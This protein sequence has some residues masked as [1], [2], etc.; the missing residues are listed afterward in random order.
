MP[1]IGSQNF[2]QNRCELYSNSLGSVMTGAR[3]EIVQPSLQEQIVQSESAF[4]E[5]SIPVGKIKGLFNEFDAVLDPNGTADYADIQ[6]ALSDGKTHLYLK[7][8]T[9][10]LTA[11]LVIS[12]NDVSIQGESRE[13]VIIQS[14]ATEGAAN[15]IIDISGDRCTIGNIYKTG[16]N[17]STPFIIAVSGDDCVIQN[18]HIKNAVSG[19]KGIY[20]DTGKGLKVINCVIET[21]LYP[22]YTTQ[23]QSQILD[24]YIDVANGNSTGFYLGGDGGMFSR[25]RYIRAGTG[26]YGVHV[27]GTNWSVTDNFMYSSSTAGG[28][29]V[30]VGGSKNKISGNRI[31]GFY[32]GIH[33]SAD[34]GVTIE[35]N[36][37]FN[38]GNNGID[39]QG[40][41][42]ASYGHHVTANNTIYTCGGNGISLRYGQGHIIT[43]NSVYDATY[44][45]FYVD[46]TVN[47]F[48]AIISHNQAFYCNNGFVGLQ[49]SSFHHRCSWIGNQAYQSV[50]KGFDINQYSSNIIGNIDYAGGAASSFVSM[51]G[52]VQY[53]I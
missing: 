7:N 36:S 46:T 12:A 48:M 19:L 35:N 8:G 2:S 4:P 45:G 34:Y 31:E 26:S 40:A 44:N 50:A 32:N 14:G 29:A 10:I 24:N 22:V 18:C 42:G 39:L 53:N 17:T 25:N 15:W 3:T 51:S 20:A 1:I 33:N 41:T 38:I 37:M 13:G 49:G 52:N 27:A 11:N 9:Y 28:L 6:K 30:Y 21:S 43:G 47:C 23:N 16:A 5:D